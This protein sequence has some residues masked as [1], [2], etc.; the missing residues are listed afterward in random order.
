MQD[1]R[2]IGREFCRC[3]TCIGLAEDREPGERNKYK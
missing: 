3:A 1:T 2:M